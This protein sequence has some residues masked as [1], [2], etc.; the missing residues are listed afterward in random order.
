MLGATYFPQPNDGQYA[1]RAPSRDRKEMG[2]KALG[3]H[4]LPLSL[5]EF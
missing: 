3:F 1:H 4:R 5:T 2:V